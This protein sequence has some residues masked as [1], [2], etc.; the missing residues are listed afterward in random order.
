MRGALKDDVP[1][2]ASDPADTDDARSGLYNTDLVVGNIADGRPED[3]RMVCADACDNRRRRR[4]DDICRIKLAADTDFDAV[5]VDITP[6]CDQKCQQR[7]HFELSEIGVRRVNV[8]RLCGKL[9]G[10]S[11]EKVV[12]D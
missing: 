1:C 11:H 2:F 5:V 12:R 8:S 9:P 3:I 4:R 6:A 7:L 10:C